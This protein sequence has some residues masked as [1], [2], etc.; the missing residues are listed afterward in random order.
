[1]NIIKTTFIG[2]ALSLLMISC[3]GDEDEKSLSGLEGDWDAIEFSATIVGNSAGQ[4]FTNEVEATTLDYCLTLENGQFETSGGYDLLTT[5][6]VPGVSI[7][8]VASSITNVS[9]SGEYTDNGS[10]L[11]INGG[12][13]ELELN[14]VPDSALQDMP[15]TS[16]YSFDADD[17]LVFE[18]DETMTVTDQGVTVTVSIV[19]RSVWQRK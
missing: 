9:G 12:F 17:N 19:S 14:G 15:Q 2:L 13:Y 10:S 16:D 18:Q 4:T 7:P 1:M 11:E 6:T 5:V 8:P 3:G